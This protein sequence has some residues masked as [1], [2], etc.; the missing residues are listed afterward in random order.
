MFGASGILVALVDIYALVSFTVAR[1]ER[2]MGIRLA[3]GASPGGLKVFVVSGVLR[4]VVAGVVIGIGVALLGAQFLT[5]F[6]YQIP[7][8]DPRHWRSA[9]RRSFWLP[10]PRVMSRRVTPHASIR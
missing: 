5:P 7:A 2:E 4:W 10:L 6:V 9:R 1:R 3:L 8:N